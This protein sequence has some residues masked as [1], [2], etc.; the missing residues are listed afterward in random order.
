MRIGASGRHW[1]SQSNAPSS[2]AGPVKAYPAAIPAAG[3]GNEEEAEG[4]KEEA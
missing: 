2:I 3:G 4:C 1:P